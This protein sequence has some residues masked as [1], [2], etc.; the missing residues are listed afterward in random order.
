MV[1]DGTKTLTHQSS[2]TNN[3]PRDPLHGPVI[4]NPLR[5]WPNLRHMYS[6]IYAIGISANVTLTTRNPTILQ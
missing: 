1:L 2:A 5:A 6:Y 4:W 3:A